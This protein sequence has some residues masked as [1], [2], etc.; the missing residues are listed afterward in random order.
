[1]RHA[2]FAA[3]IFLLI[4]VAAAQ[5]QEKKLLDRLLKPNTTLQNE[6]QGKQ[7]VAGN[8]S[9]TKNAQTKT[10]YV[11]ERKTEKSFGSDRQYPAPG[12]TT[13]TSRFSRMLA[14]VAP[15][16]KTAKMNEAYATGGYRDLHPASDG[17]KVRPTSSYPGNRTFVAQGKS[18]KSLSAQDRPMTID[19]VR[20]LLNKNK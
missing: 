8:S 4:R 3:L 19:E 2:I 13:K 14:H 12:F 1:M 15:R 20:E 10:F 6:A 18:Q 16:F 5:E 11:G 7:F 17:N 9:P